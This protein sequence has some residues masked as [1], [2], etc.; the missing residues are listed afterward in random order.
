MFKVRAGELMEVVLYVQD[1]NLM[2]SF[3][4][5][6]LGLNVKEPEAVKDFRDFYWVMFSTGPCSLVLHAGGKR[7]L[8]EDTPKIVFRVENIHLVRDTLLEKSV[9]LGEIQSHTPDVLACDGHDPEGNAFSL[10]S[11]TNEA[12]KSMMTLDMPNAPPTYVS[13]YSKRGRSIT[14]LRDNKLVIAAELALIV[15]LICLLPVLKFVPLFAPFLLIMTLLWLR[16]NT[17]SKLGMAR[18]VSWQRTVLLGLSFG[19][20]FWLLQL[21]VIVPAM[22]SFVHASPNLRTISDVHG[23]FLYLLAAL[24]TSWTSAGFGEE[25]I[26]RGY[27]LNRFSDLFGNNFVGWTLAL[28]AQAVVFG[29]AHTYQ[30]PAGVIEVGIYGLLLG[31]LYLA[32]KRNLWVCAA[33]HGINDT[34]T[35]VLTFLF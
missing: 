27:L 29:A 10:E 22:K 11:R 20:F 25:M 18:P 6:T 30:G 9:Q 26:F 17:W 14:L 34:I 31:L 4:R 33:A 13:A 28:F 19:I 21:F 32:T 1:M 16:G 12:V 7:Q 15:A 24:I 35:L 2:V 5:D 23:H 3:Y 8:G